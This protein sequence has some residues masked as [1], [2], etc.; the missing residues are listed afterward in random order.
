MLKVKNGKIIRKISTRF[1]LANRKKNLIAVMAIMLTCILFTAVFSIGG[2]MLKSMQESTFRQV[3]GRHMAGL[4]YAFQKDYD[5]LEKDPAVKDI[6]KN[7]IVGRADNA[8][9]TDLN[10]E[11]NYA[12]DLYARETF[13]YP[14]TGS[15]PKERLEI[16]ASSLVL[17][18]MGIPLEIGRKVPL[19]LNVDGKVYEEEFTLCGFWEGDPVAMA[20]ECWISRELADEVAPAPTVPFGKNGSFY[21][22]YYNIQ[23]NFANSWDIEGQLIKVLERNGYDVDT[24]AYG[25]NWGYTTSEID[26]QSVILVAGV[27]LIIMISGYLIIYNVFY[28]N[29]TGEIHEY[30]LLKTI[31]TTAGQLRKLVRRQ[32]VILSLV[33]IPFGMILGTVLS[34]VL[35]PVILGNFLTFKVSFSIH[36]VIYLASIV[37]TFATVLMSCEKPCR[38]AS[39][40]SPMEALRYTEKAAVKNKEKK[41]RRVSAF[42]MAVGNIKRSRKKVVVVVL[43]LSMSMLLVNSIYNMVHSFDMETYISNSIMGDFQVT[44]SS[45][46][47]MSSRV[48]IYDGISQEELAMFKGL[49]G[50][51]SV[52]AVYS[53]AHASALLD[54]EGV[55]KIK[56]YVNRHN[57]LKKDSW[58]MEELGYIEE[59]EFCFANIYGI[60][61][62]TFDALR[63]YA[64]N[65][66][67]EKFATGSYCL[68]YE[69]E[70][71]EEEWIFGPG[72]KITL[73]LENGDKKEY[74][75]LAVAALPYSMST[76]SYP[77]LGISPVLPDTEYLEHSSSTGALGISMTVKEDK[78]AEVETFLSSYT[79]NGNDELTCVSRQTYVDEFEGFVSMFWIVGGALSFILALIGILN[80]INAIVTG[81]LTRKQEFAMMEAVGMTRKQLRAM[82]VFE[83]L[84]YAGLTLGFSLTAG[85]VISRLLVNMAA[86]MFWFFRYSYVIWPVLACAPVL[87]AL[88]AAIPFG[89]YGQMSRDSIVERLKLI[90]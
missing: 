73:E 3:G 88:A 24:V 17:E 65:I 48:K 19:L 49:D 76:K 58:V 59:Q 68:L 44:H 34:K 28:I 46:L 83:G 42:T 86:G 81:I 5:I 36:P 71:K 60:D 87:V 53:S 23:F 90:E 67:W 69:L 27:L 37:F 33:G 10:V 9:L 55:Q 63:I 32:A 35:L 11:I 21:A 75:V 47:N 52:A 13:C 43:S 79:E 1:L 18:A 74:E 85:N 4:K 61:Q 66:S 62:N 77:L 54:G 6:C 26:I 30:G 14:E 51:E 56:D 38:L 22:G 70:E 78:A 39:K 12:D 82:L 7:I 50:V 2:S 89:A 72:D 64:G 80:F 31:G 57:S 29:V 15:M 41:S 8:E 25:I 84:L 40:V 45:V 20:Q 16:A